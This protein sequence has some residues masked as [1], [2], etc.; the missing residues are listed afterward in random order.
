[1]RAAAGKWGAAGQAGTGRGGAGRRTGGLRGRPRPAARP[2]GGRILAG[3]ARAEPPAPGR[4][5]T[6]IR[7]GVPA[8][9]AAGREYPR[10]S[11]LKIQKYFVVSTRAGWMRPE[12]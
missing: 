2:R 9:A 7:G 10:G 12:W 6:R 3:A 5:R 4:A 1:M 8:P 11:I